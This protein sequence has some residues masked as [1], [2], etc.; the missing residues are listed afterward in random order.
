ML[1]SCKGF[2]VNLV[3]FFNN[4]KLAQRIIFIPMFFLGEDMV[5]YG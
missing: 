5:L 3:F 2:P 1:D 4:R